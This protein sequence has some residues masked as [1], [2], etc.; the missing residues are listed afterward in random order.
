MAIYLFAIAGAGNWYTRAHMWW[1]WLWVYKVLGD[2]GITSTAAM[3]DIV[4]RANLDLQNEAVAVNTGLRKTL[5]AALR[6][7]GD[8]HAPAAKDSRG[9]YLFFR[10]TCLF[11]CEVV[12]I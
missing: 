8:K 12:S 9:T 10:G 11:S 3:A 2:C 1:S 4:H 5:L 7:T 6:Q